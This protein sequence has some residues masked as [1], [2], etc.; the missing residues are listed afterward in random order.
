MMLHRRGTSGSAPARDVIAFP[1]DRQLSQRAVRA[2]TFSSS[3][4]GQLPLALAMEQA[5]LD[6]WGMGDPGRL[7]RDLRKTRLTWKE[8]T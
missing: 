7:S 2:T 3:I 5:A 6:R 1:E 8:L 4:A